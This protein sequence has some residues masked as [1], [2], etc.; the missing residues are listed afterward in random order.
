MKFQ[1]N[2]CGVEWNTSHRIFRCPKCKAVQPIENY[3][4]AFEDL[5]AQYEEEKQSAGEALG[6][7]H[8]ANEVYKK[9][10]NFYF[11]TTLICFI[12]VI[13]LLSRLL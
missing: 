13:V 11:I 10:R 12:T 1:C 7:M 8:R 4:K 5:Y 2:G 3:K 9:E 6:I